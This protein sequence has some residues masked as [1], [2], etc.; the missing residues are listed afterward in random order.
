MVSMIFVSNCPARPT[1]RFAAR[2][3]IRARRFSDEHEIGVRVADAENS[4][5]AA[6]GEV[7]TFYANANLFAQRCEKLLFVRRQTPELAQRTARGAR[8]T[9]DDHAF[10][11]AR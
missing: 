8:W 10:A 1:K 3:F 5:G 4:L 11:P 9:L 2:I 7:R 6:R